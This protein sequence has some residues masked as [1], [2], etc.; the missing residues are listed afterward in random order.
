MLLASVRCRRLKTLE[1]RG[2]SGL[3]PPDLVLL[4]GMLHGCGPFDLV[5]CAESE[6]LGDARSMAESR[7]WCVAAGSAHRARL[8]LKG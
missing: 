1:L 4:L 3:A 5:I 2:C 6:V 7:G 8:H